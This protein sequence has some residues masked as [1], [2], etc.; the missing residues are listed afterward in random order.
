MAILLGIGTVSAGA[1]PLIPSPEVVPAAFE[2]DLGLGD[3][4]GHT[5]PL[6]HLEGHGA[7]VVV[8]H[9]PAGDDAVGEPA[10]G[11]GEAVD[12]RLRPVLGRDGVRGHAETLAAC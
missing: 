8:T 10:V 4:T 11:E 5:V 3:R 9:E 6:Q 12:D 1:A 2:G 7:G